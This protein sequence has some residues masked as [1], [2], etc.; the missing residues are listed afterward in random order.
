MELTYTL[1]DVRSE[2][3]AFLFYPESWNGSKKL[4]LMSLE[5]IG[6]FINLLAWTAQDPDCSIE[7]DDNVLAKLSG[8]GNEKWTASASIIRSCFI[9]HAYRKHYLTNKKL[10]LE[11]I[12]L[13]G[14][15]NKKKVKAKNAAE[16]RWE[17]QREK[18]EIEKKNVKDMYLVEQEKCAEDANASP[19]HEENK[20]TSSKS[21][22]QKCLS[23]SNSISNNKTTTSSTKDNE[24]SAILSTLNIIHKA[25]FNAP[26]LPTQKDTEIVQELL[27]KGFNKAQIKVNYGLFCQSQDPYLKGKNR[28][29]PLFKTQ[30]NNYL[31]EANQI[32]KNK[33]IEQKQQ[34]TQ[35]TLEA[36]QLTKADEVIW[37]QIL[38]RIEEKELPENFNTW[39]KPIKPKGRVSNKFFVQV[40][41]D[42]F[43]RTLIESYQDVI[44]EN[45]SAIDCTIKKIDFISRECL[46]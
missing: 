46:S 37:N 23:I 2:S 24:I 26:I 21:D 10:I 17:K 34:K 25:N 22:A 35:K 27:E 45:L 18:N 41:N 4:S 20:K 33:E 3:P 39:F 31:S 16:K 13:N 42:Y 14:S 12:K 30:I 40:P 44:L 11:R 29:L 7:D 36:I 5:E 6:A 43:K 19:K 28:A 1:E 32:I 15:K 9:P 38:E 8:L